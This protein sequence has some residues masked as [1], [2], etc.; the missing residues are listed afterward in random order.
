M[1]TW[2]KERFLQRYAIENFSKFKPFG[3]KIISVRDNKD[4]YP[5]LFCILENGKEVPAEVEWRSGNFVQHGH[6]INEL[7]D[8]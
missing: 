5:D 2:L 3:L 7:K 1:E 8:N 6:D 4:R